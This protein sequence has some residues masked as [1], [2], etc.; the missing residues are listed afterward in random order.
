MISD[1]RE[2]EDGSIIDCD[3]AI[4][5]GGAAG[6]A[7]AHRLAGRRLKVLL[8]ESGG[9]DYSPEAQAL[10]D[11]LNVGRPYFD[12]D[13]SRLRYFGGSTNHW[14]GRCRPLD[15]LDFEPRP[16]VPLSGWPISFGDLVPWYREAQELCGLGD[17]S[18]DAESWLGE[19]QMLLPADP[20]KLVSRVWQYSPP[21]LFGEAYRSILGEASNVEV[22]LY[23]NLTGIG[24]APEGGRVDQ[25]EVRTLDGTGFMVRPRQAV[26]ALGGLENPR[27]MLAAGRQAGPA[28]GNQHDMVGRCF[29][30]HPHANGGRVIG[31][32]PNVLGFYS[33]GI[34]AKASP[35]LEVVGCLSL[36][37]GVQKAHEILNFDSLFTI[38]NVGDSGFAALRRIW[39]AAEGGGVP[40]DLAADLWAA[41][42]DLD[43]TAAGLLGRFGVREYRPSHGSFR[44][45]STAEQAPDRDSRVILG[46]E[47]DQLG[48]PRIR[49][50]WRLSELDK[51]TVALAHET[52][53]TELGRTGYGRLQIDDW[54]LA[55]PEVW[56]DDVEGGHHHMGTTRMSD[57]PKMG[58]VDRNCRVHGMENLYVAGSSVFP[59]SGAANPTLTVVALARRLAAHLEQSLQS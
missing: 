46:D 45:W 47:V 12:L 33:R 3:L 56:S 28:P 51:R 54:V 18:Y 31:T 9:L 44:L 35:F 17:L 36:A 23:A 32:D 40:A 14:A 34:G 39:K 10:Y 48:M 4:G 57:D 42:V 30:E 13:V 37:P 1:A 55:G 27:L 26:L 41:L 25:L 11:G 7:I 22:L 6:I 21:V 15:P 43:D 49:L 53:A 29:M 59:T 38:D 16:W 19:D 58:V 20:D 8:L 5:G 52:I 50:N 24:R 2:I